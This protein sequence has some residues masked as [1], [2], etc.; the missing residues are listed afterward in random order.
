MSCFSFENHVP[1][2]I[3]ISLHCS[4]PFPTFETD[5][6]WVS[7][8]FTDLPTENPA[9][10]RQL[11]LSKT[12]NHTIVLYNNFSNLFILKKNLIQLAKKLLLL[13]WI[14]L[15]LLNSGQR[16]VEGN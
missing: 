5:H 9:K 1:K 6:H 14:F 4:A 7:L 13:L 8:K 11:I 2:Q 3:P 12:F 16:I 15:S 10:P